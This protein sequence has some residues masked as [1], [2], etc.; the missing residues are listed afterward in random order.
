M[1]KIFQT[2]EVGSLAKPR[3]R[4]KGYKG[5][6]LLKE[7]VAEAVNWG[8]KL[9]IENLNELVKLLSERDSPNR[10][11]ALLEWSAKY[12]LRFFEKAGLDIVFDGEQWR[13]EMYE[14]IIKN[15]AGFKFLGYVKSFDYRYFNKAACID[16]PKYARPFY[17]DEFVFTKENT[18]K[19]VKVP[20]T[21][22]YTLVDWT[23]N[24]YYEKKLRSEIKDF[25]WRKFEA[26]KEFL[27][28]LIKKV[29]KPEIRKLVNSGATWIQID[30]PAATTNPT[31]K[32]MELFVESFNETVK[33]FNCAF[34]LHNCY[35]NY[36]VLA[37]YACKLRDCNQLT[38]EF[39]NR[40]SRQT[41]IGAARRGYKD[42]KLF[43]DYGYRGNYGLGV[44][45]VHT[46]FVEP[47]ELVR[48][49]ILHVA[50]IIGDPSRIYVSTDCG[51]RT[52]TWEIGFQKL[53]SMVLGA[54]LARK[55]FE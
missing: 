50:K 1:D 19:K 7:E 17:L 47:P 34:S 51:L 2:Q 52:R 45:D 22:P 27:F 33:G 53:R 8:R 35:S 6:P 20:F 48:D 31:D 25:K 40:D 12:A 14:H 29:I 4:I 26:K 46:D 21:G 18:E 11:K 49:R 39:A 10:R 30:E 15:V 9:G 37:R 5:E 24:E 55:A 3:W 36:E 43:E 32:E 13:S 38:L 41:G 16:K 42:V 54:E 28:D 23:F 44:V